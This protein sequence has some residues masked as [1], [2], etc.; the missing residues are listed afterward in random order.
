MSHSIKLQHKEFR[1][2]DYSLGPKSSLW[3]RS[4]TGSVSALSPKG[5][6][7]GSGGGKGNL[8]VDFCRVTGTGAFNPACATPD[9]TPEQTLNA[10]AVTTA[11]NPAATASFLLP[12]LGDGAGKLD[13]PLMFIVNSLP[14]KP[15]GRNLRFAAPRNSIRRI[16]RLR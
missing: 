3:M 12:L 8:G 10:T 6:V 13:P 14:L 9:E 2:A 5:P 16:C 15:V 7:E 1:A 11:P 4:K